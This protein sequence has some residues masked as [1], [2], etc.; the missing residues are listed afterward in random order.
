MGGIILLLL[1]NSHL[2]VFFTSLFTLLFFAVTDVVWLQFW[3]SFLV[4]RFWFGFWLNL[5]GFRFHFWLK[6]LG[7][8]VPMGLCLCCLA[9]YFSGHSGL[10]SGFFPS[11]LLE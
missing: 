5:I 1:L 11:L 8:L 6:N 10:R 9:N 2:H 7:I 3:I 4:F